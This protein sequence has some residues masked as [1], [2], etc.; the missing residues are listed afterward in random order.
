MLV[1]TSGFLVADIIVANLPR[2]ASP[3][4]VLFA[5]KGIHLHMGGHP[6]NVAIDLVKLGLDPSDIGVVGAIG[7]D[8][9]G[10]FIENSIKSY[11]INVFLQRVPQMCT[12][13]N[14][15]L[16]VKGEDR[17]FHVD[18][19]A[20]WYL[21]PEHVR[22]T[23]IRF[24]PKIFYSAVGITGVDLEISRIVKG[25]RYSLSF[26]DVVRPYGKDW[27]FILPTL[28]Y[29]DAFH[30]NEAEALSITGEGNVILALRKLINYGA[31]IVF[32]TRGER[33]ALLMTKHVEISQ[34][35]FK[36]KVIDPTGAGDAFCAG[37]ISKLIGLETKNIQ[38]TSSEELTKILTYG[39][40]AGALACTGIGTTTA[41][42]KK[43]V[44]RILSE[45]EGKI[46][47]KTVVTEF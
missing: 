34:P 8:P 7:A 3:S 14:V 31:K 39:Q 26:F 5:P 27:H 29:A 37:V 19:G 10:D 32:V 13:K 18:L 17:R 16:V 11:G 15:I 30:C 22:K 45:Q 4:E 9:F 43:D 35:S 33:G 40:A 42:S 25:A 28:K 36:V 21:D 38:K 12:T 47:R 6:A 41:V 23:L 46:M 24:K 1:L 2:V 44:D 20:S